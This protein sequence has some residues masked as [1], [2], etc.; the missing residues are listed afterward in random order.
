MNASRYRIDSSPFLA[1]L[2][3]STKDALLERSTLL[4]VAAGKEV[5]IEGH[6]PTHLMIALDGPVEMFARSRNKRT[7][8]ALNPTGT[9][10]I[11]AAV[12]MNA[13]CLMS[14]RTISE[15]RIL[16]VPA[17]RFREVLHSNTELAVLTAEELSRGFRTMVRQVRWQKLRSA[18]LRLATYLLQECEPISGPVEIVLK[19]PKRLLAS[20]LGLE[21]E[22]LSRTFADLGQAGVQ[23][24]GDVITIKDVGVLRAIATYDDVIDKPEP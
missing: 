20:M 8:I 19:I 21:P 4:E 10:F 6:L 17:V 9:P 12:V 18:K 5:L 16:C 7:T 11:L 2:S 23:V 1:K 3:R 24:S 14:A 13:A 22:S 15:G